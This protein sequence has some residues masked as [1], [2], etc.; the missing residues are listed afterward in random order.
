MNA[1]A[2]TT[3]QDA[4][5]LYTSPEAAR[6]LRKSDGTLANWRSQKRGPRYC[7][8]GSSV[9]YRLSDLRRFLDT[10]SVDPE[11]V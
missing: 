10:H 7:L 2:R 5:P 9:V 6:Y 1:T 4:D 8:T 11:A 3:Q